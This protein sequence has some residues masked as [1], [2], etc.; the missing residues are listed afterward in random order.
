MG[1]LTGRR[2]GAEIYEYFAED[3]TSREKVRGRRYK[4]CGFSFLKFTLGTVMSRAI[5]CHN[6]AYSGTLYELV[7]WDGK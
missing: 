3:I 2:A 6:Y 1:S 7:V 4:Y 5:Q